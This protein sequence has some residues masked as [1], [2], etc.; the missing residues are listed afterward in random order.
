MTGPASRLA[1]YVRGSYPPLP[2]LVFAVL[3]AYGVTGL[4]AA[5]DPEPS[6]WRPGP[7][8][9]V[10]ALTLFA[11]LLLMRALDDTRDLEYDR[12]FHSARPLAA[13]D[14]R[15]GD[16][17]ALYGAVAPVLVL[18]NAAWPWRAGI[19]LV[20]LGYAAGAIAVHRRWRRP[21]ADDL[22]ASLLVG[23]PVP[24]LLHLYLY[25][26]YL[27][28]SGHR[29]GAS[30]AVAVVVVVLAAGHHELA[31]KATRA[32]EAG[33]RTYVT[34]LGLTGTVAL[35]TAV[36]VLSACLL[37]AFSQAPAGWTLAAPVPLVS[38]ALAAWAVRR[39]RTRWPPGAPGAY[40]LLSFASYLVLGL[41]R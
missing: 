15:T 34:T 39:G 21:S 13:G 2:S 23:L 20:Q 28:A 29:P 22:F 16:L 37:A 3:W 14:V 33:E 6:G 11:N 8:T 30:G 25:A 10:A 18:L 36:P 31:G 9:A 41:A 19:L 12:R 7:G 35:A 27:D 1:R 17:A 4:F 5:L 24:V 38:P 40:L 32:P 26:G